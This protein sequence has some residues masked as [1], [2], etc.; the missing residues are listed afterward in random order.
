MAVNRTRRQS[1]GEKATSFLRQKLEELK[2][3]LNKGVFRSSVNY[4]Y[5]FHKWCSE[6]EYALS[7]V[8]GEDSKQLKRFVNASELPYLKGTAY[9]LSQHRLKSMV[10]ASAELE[11]ILSS[12]EEYG[13]PEKQE[14]T[15][16]PKAFIAHGGKS[17]ALDKLCSFIEALGVEPLVVEVEPSEGRL[18][19][20]QVNKY[21][22]QADCAIIL[23]TYGHIEDVKTHKKH[24]RLNVV[25]ELGR[26]RKVFPDKTILLLEKGVNLPSNVSGIVYEHFT[27]ENMEKAFIKVAAELRAFR[28]IRPIKPVG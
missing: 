26:C 3:L 25:D 11:A 14:G 24:P 6:T 17:A 9:Q 20:E 18:T 10:R 4:H 28:L 19:E 21:T 2:E 27:N 8:F 15:M 12:I 22:K 5:S 16:L 23:A 7:Q 1:N 13:I